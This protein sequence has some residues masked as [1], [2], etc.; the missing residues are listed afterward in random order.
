MVDGGSVY[1]HVGG[2]FAGDVTSLRTVSFEG[3]EIHIAGDLAYMHCAE[4]WSGGNLRVDG[5][6]AAIDVDGFFD[7]TATI[8]NLSGRFNVRRR[9]CGNRGVRHNFRGRTIHRGV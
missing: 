3:G 2:E 5:D 7:G 8:K 1:V 4:N 9:S 6:V